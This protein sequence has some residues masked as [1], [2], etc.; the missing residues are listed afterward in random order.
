[1]N[2]GGVGGV[3]SLAVAGGATAAPVATAG[4][5]GGGGETAPT[6][7]P[8]PS[9]KVSISDGAQQ[10]L[11]GELLQVGA[12]LSIG[13]DASGKLHQGGMD[14]NGFSA[15][16]SSSLNGNAS[17]NVTVNAFGQDLAALNK[18]DEL[19]VA[20]ILLKLLEKAGH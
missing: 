10:A 16:Q 17:V 9:T 6:A 13:Q 5:A 3:A 11:S 7:A 19:L 12:S 20:M 14:Q 8:Q 4:T 1:M 2:M 18:L 15:G